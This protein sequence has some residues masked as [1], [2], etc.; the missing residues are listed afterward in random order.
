[1]ASSVPSNPKYLTGTASRLISRPSANSPTA[2][3]TPPAPKSLAFLIRRVQA[4][5]LNKRCSLRSTRAFPFCT[6]EEH[7]SRDVSLCSFEEPVAPP[8]P[9]RPVAPPNI[10]MISPGKGFSR[11]T[12]LFGAAPTTAPTSIRLATYPSSNISSTNVVARPIWFP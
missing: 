7:F 5:F 10:T 2:T 12:W 11:F 6:S 4:G 3:E 9:S 1:M 8:I